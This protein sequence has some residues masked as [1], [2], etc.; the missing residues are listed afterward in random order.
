MGGGGGGKGVF[1]RFSQ[2]AILKLCEFISVRIPL[3][4]W[5]KATI[6][7]NNKFVQ[8]ENM[9]AYEWRQ[10]WS[11]EIYGCWLTINVKMCNKQTKTTLV[12]PSYDKRCICVLC[13]KIWSGLWSRKKGFHKPK[14][15]AFFLSLTKFVLSD[16]GTRGPISQSCLS[17]RFAAKIFSLS[18]Y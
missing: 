9:I 3:F 12:P 4:V 13:V 18:K 7:T 17:V 14:T 2:K 15:G 8:K 16:P 6:Q 11:S 10:L 1:L 5:C